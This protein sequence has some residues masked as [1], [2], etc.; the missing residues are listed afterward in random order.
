MRAD[1]LG[2]IT[3]SQLAAN[4]GLSHTWIK[5]IEKRIKLPLWGSGTRGKKSYYTFE[6]QEL[7][8]KIAVLRKLDIEFD[9]IKDLY[10]I[11]KEITRFLRKHFPVD[12]S[13]RNEKYANVYLIQSIQGGSTGIE[14]DADKR[15]A[16]KE[17]D[18]ELVKMYE[19]YANMIKI[20]LKRADAQ[21]FE[22]KA[23]KEEFIGIAGMK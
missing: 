12:D 4:V 6:Q 8:R 21:I 19:T 22:L 1:S 11:E 17:L 18:K 7:F 20:V 23:A 5:K 3:L 14:Y 16:N 10:D 13:T 15:A 2:E 9:M